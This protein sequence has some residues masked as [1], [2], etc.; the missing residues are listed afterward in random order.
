[1]ISTTPHFIAGSEVIEGSAMLPITDPATGEVI[2]EVPLADSTVVASAI[3]AAAAAWPKWRDTSLTKRASILNQF[4]NL[5]SNQA[6]DLASLVCSEH[7]KVPADAAGEITR[8]LE[9]ADYAT[10]LIEHLKGEYSN[11]S[12]RGSISTPSG[13]RLVWWL[14]SHHS[15]SP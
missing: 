3:D 5:L 9:N 11:R 6:D 13:N 1:M 7:G 10:G 14:A 2:R 8:G 15:I 4:R 12:P